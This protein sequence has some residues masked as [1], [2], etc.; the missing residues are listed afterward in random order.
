MSQAGQG[1][2]VTPLE[3]GEMDAFFE[4]DG[5]AFGGRMSPPIR[6]L[7]EAHM[8]AQRVLATR[9]GDEVVGTTVSERSAITVPGLNRLPAGLVMGVAV[10]PSHRRQGRLTALMRRQLD[11]MRQGGE[12]LAALYASEGGI[13]GRFGY[14]MATFGS[15]FELDKRVARLDPAATRRTSGRI[16]LL[17]RDKAAEAFPAVY[18]EYAPTRAGEIDRH[19]V[20]DFLNVL[21]DPGAEDL[22]RRFYAVYE[23][24]GRI[25]GYV[26]YEVVPVTSLPDVW[27]RRVICHE[28]CHLTTPAYVALWQFLLGIDLTEEIQASGRP[29]DEPLRWLLTVPRHLRTVFSGDRSWIRLV[30]VPKALAGRRYPQP[31]TLTLDVEDGFCSWNAGRYRLHVSEEWA[32]GEVERTEGPA[33]IELDVSTLASIYLGAVRPS[34]FAMSERICEKTGGALV[35]AD[36]MFA[37][38]RPP[39][40]LSEF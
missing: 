21:G 32:P 8:T 30:D 3:E 22:S 7:I 24:G 19:N 6:E 28:L 23:E 29:V 20:L 9:D 1:L 16:R 12:V 11:E 36:R 18:A 34:Q 15:R 35:R 10:A 38:D 39:S 14:G 4:I 37:S 31:G 26:G 27:A 17:D 2:D 33:D 13:Y 5:V 40:C 25:D